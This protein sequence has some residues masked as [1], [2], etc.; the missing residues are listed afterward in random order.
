M[1]AAIV[2]KNRTQAAG[3][4]NIPADE[5]FIRSEKR[6]L[7]LMPRDLLDI[8]IDYYMRIKNDLLK[9]AKGEYA[10]IHGERLIDTFGSK[11][12]A[13]KKGYQMFG[14]KPF[15]VRKIT[16]TETPLFFTSYLI[17]AESAK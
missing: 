5:C 13:M 14:N 17:S 3:K 11:E 15:L 7:I 10:L 9:R 16:E 8:E 4:V 6:E 12:D 2:A 1:V